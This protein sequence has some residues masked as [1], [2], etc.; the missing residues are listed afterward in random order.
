[1]RLAL[2]T[3]RLEGVTEEVIKAAEHLAQMKEISP[4]KTKAIEQ[5]LAAV[6]RERRWSGLIKRLAKLQSKYSGIE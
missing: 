4:Q 3:K 1:M 2:V 6:E 5:H